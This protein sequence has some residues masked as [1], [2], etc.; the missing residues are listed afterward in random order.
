[1]PLKNA[2]PHLMAADISSEAF[3]IISIRKFY[4][5]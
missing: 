1:M 2:L 4:R 5:K 3:I